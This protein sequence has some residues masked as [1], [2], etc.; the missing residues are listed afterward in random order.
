M[1]R[2]RSLWRMTVRMA[3]RPGGYGGGVYPAPRRSV[4]EQIR[5]DM[6]QLVIKPTVPAGLLDENTKFYVNPTGRLVIGGP[7]GDSGLTGGRIIVDTYGGS[8]PTAAARSPARTPPRWT[9]PPLA[10]AGCQE[11]GGRRLARTAA[12]C[13]WPMP[14]AWPGPSKRAGGD[15]RHRQ[16]IRHKLE[17]A[18]EKV[19]DLRPTPLSGTWICASPSTASWRPTATWAVRIWA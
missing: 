14:L 6:I 16:G 12:R 4:P 2:P 11:R 15:F 18:V 7:Q 17:E 13:S 9:G 8:A 1:A 10:P 19:F 5:E 3:S